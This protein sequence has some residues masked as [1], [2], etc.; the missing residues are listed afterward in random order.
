MARLAFDCEPEAVDGQG[1]SASGRGEGGTYS[2]S[3]VC[4]YSTLCWA[5]HHPMP[6]KR[7]TRSPERPLHSLCDSSGPRGFGGAAGSSPKTPPGRRKQIA[8]LKQ[9][10]ELRDDQL[11]NAKAE[12]KRLEQDLELLKGKRQA[13]QNL[14]ALLTS[15]R[16]QLASA[17]G[18][19]LAAPR[20]TVRPSREP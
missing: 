6:H 12:T 4:E 3:A 5:A 20:P 13:R 1:D 14:E 16:E 19:L 2:A 7:N 17:Q 18:H 8:Q 15:L 9:R 11:A 10:L